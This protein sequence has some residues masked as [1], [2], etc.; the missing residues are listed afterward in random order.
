MHSDQAKT[1]YSW[2]LLLLQLHP[3][4]HTHSLDAVRDGKT[5]RIFVTLTFFFSWESC[6]CLAIVALIT[7]TFKN[8]SL[9]LLQFSRMQIKQ[10]K[11]PA[12]FP[13]KQYHINLRSNTKLEALY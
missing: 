11:T 6:Q 2:F 4:L 1:G 13:Q 10:Q 12:L 5:L 7:P 3:C 8:I 9:Y